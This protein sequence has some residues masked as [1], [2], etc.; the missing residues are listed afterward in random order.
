MKRTVLISFLAL[1]LSASYVQAQM[2]QGMMGGSSQEEY[3]ED[4]G[5]GMMGYGRGM[6]YG[7]GRGMGYGM[8]QQ[9]GPYGRRGPHYG[10]GYGP[11]WQ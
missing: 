6:G 3:S 2:G 1:V 10:Q 4:M 11:C 7:M 9:Y 5:P 8:G